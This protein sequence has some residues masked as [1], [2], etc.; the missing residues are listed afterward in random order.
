MKDSM[1]FLHHKSKSDG[2][3]PHI[4]EN[5]NWWIGMTDTKIKGARSQKGRYHCP[6]VQINAT[7]NEWEIS[8]D[9][10]K[11][12]N[13]QGLRRPGRKG[14]KVMR[15]L[16]KTGGPQVILIMSYS[17]WLTERPSWP[18]HVPKYYLCQVQGW[19]RYFL[20]VT[21]VSNTIDIEFIGLTTENYKAL[22]AEL[23][24]EDGTIDIEIV[25]R[26]ENKDVKL[27]NLYLRMGKCTKRQSKSTKKE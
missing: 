23:R 10:G 13:R 11:T 21:S 18:Y 20:P 14:D 9:G 3:T 22:V 17:L 5:G 27:R 15:Y 8:T 6:Q 25:P 19:L 24:S 1:I 4:G 12:G 7:T 26:A 16:R 2:I